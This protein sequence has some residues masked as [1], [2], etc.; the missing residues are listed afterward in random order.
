M[1]HPLNQTTSP[2][3]QTTDVPIP[4]LLSS[5]GPGLLLA[6]PYRS[7][8]RLD[9]PGLRLEH[10][11]VVE[12]DEGGALVLAEGHE[13]WLSLEEEGSKERAVARRQMRGG[14]GKGDEEGKED[15]PV[16]AYEFVVRGWYAVLRDGCYRGSR[17]A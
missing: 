1:H 17:F 7:D 13:G 10:Q 6:T 5:R 11:N 9:S 8:W 15:D 12:L 16:G 3:I 14:Q 4:F 2:S